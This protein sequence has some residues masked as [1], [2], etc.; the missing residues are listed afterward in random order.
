M[1]EGFATEF[2][3][4]LGRQ[5]ESY[6]YGLDLLGEDVAWRTGAREAPAGVQATLHAPP[7][8]AQKDR[9]TLPLTTNQ[10]AVLSG[11]DL[12]DSGSLI[13]EGWVLVQMFRVMPQL[14][15]ARLALVLNQLRKRH[16]ALRTRFVRLD[17]GGYQA[18]LFANALP[19]TVQVE[20]IDDLQSADERAQEIAGTPID[21]YGDELFQVQIVRVGT[22]VDIVVARGHHIILDGYSMGLLVDEMIKLFLGM[23][24]DPVEI[25]TEEFIRSIDLSYDVEALKR[26]EAMLEKL[27]ADPAPP[28]PRIYKPGYADT[29][30]PS[31]H[32]SKTLTVLP[33]SDDFAAVRERCRAAGITLPTFMSA[34]YAQTIGRRGGVD[35]VIISTPMARRHDVRTRNFVNYVASDCFFRLP[36]HSRG[37]NEN[38]AAIG[39]TLEDFNQVATIMDVNY[40]GEW[41]ERIAR[42]GSYGGRFNSSM[43]TGYRSTLTN[44]FQMGGEGGE[45]DLG[46]VRL[47]MLP[48][49]QFSVMT[50]QLDLRILETSNG[51]GL[52]FTYSTELFT[53]EGARDIF[54]EVMLAM[55]LAAAQ[56]E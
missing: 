34:V 26:R 39:R 45:I 43:L 44:M 42:A 4:L 5:L 53:E 54:D 14:D 6:G 55:G 18:I 24:L 11:I 31:G 41:H 23:S 51:F 7:V 13:N 46:F 10:K 2:L 25:D 48:G 37:L 9:A 28:V 35:E 33:S 47:A 8:A 36:I 15:A 50:N 49:R 16:E 20:T 27:Y 19:V 40:A 21:P 52:R 38:A 30:G 17:G 1:P 29:S 3:G 22:S 32:R 56:V 12:P